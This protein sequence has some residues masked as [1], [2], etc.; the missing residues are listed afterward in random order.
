[1]VKQRALK[2]NLSIFCRK[3]W[4]VLAST[5]FLVAAT[6]CE[7]NA[8]Y[9]TP[10][11]QDKGMVIILP[12][13]EG[14]SG[15]NRNI[16]KGLERG[17]VERALPIMH[18]GRPIPGVGMVLN[19]VDFIGN[20][21]AGERIAKRIM[22]YQDQYP[23]RP[24]HIIGHS[25][26][27]GVAIF[28]AESLPDDREIEG[29]ILLSASISSAYDTSKALSRCRQGIVNFYNKGDAAL[30][31]V[32]TAV[33]GT[34][35]GTHGPSAGL[36]GFDLPKE[37]DSD[38]KRLA[39]ENLYQVLL[40]SE[41]S[42]NALAHFSTTQVGFILKHVAPWVFSESWPADPSVVAAPSR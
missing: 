16:R 13:I 42:G 19:Q 29:L 2:P 26:G 37:S 35:D 24:V 36:I 12:G 31:G 40:T 1:M 10:E 20:R 27:G 11:R 5:L 34:V 23:G 33:M 4:M 41:M 15:A 9:M 6:G 3:G 38:E 25:G 14:E 39:Y 21:L 32:G 22:A 17:G 8:K 18:W 30:L 7:Q 28:A